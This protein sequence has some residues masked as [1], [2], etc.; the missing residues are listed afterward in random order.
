MCWSRCSAGV[1]VIIGP[2]EDRKEISGQATAKDHF[3]GDGAEVHVVACAIALKQKARLAIE[4]RDLN[5]RQ[6]A[7]AY[8]AEAEV[9]K[10]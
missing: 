9:K 1:A 8:D 3:A 2:A 10:R 6:R 4:E 5:H 7:D